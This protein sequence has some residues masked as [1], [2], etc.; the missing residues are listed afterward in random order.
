MLWKEKIDNWKNGIIQTYPNN[1]KHNFFT[2]Q[3]YVIK[4]GTNEPLLKN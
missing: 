2:K 4:F 3:K 1:I